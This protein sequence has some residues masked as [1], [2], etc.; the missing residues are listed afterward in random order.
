MIT[1]CPQGRFFCTQSLQNDVNT[2]T[3]Y[4]FN[5]MN[6]Q[7]CFAKFFPASLPLPICFPLYG[8]HTHM[9]VCMHTHIRTTHKH[10]R[11]QTVYT[12]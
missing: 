10:T 6:V 8:T 9:Y 12:P 5:S 7:V 1:H 2:V 11:Q 4:M 3:L